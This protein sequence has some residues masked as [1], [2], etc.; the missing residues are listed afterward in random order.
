MTDKARIQSEQVI[1]AICAAI[2]IDSG[3]FSPARIDAAVEALQR[4]LKAQ[5]AEQIA[6]KP[7]PAANPI[8]VAQAMVDEDAKTT[9]DRGT[10]VLGAGIVISDRGRKGRPGPIVVIRSP[11]QGNI[12]GYHACKR[13]IEYLNRVGIPAIWYD[14]VID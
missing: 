13:A 2:G 6:P 10:C 9:Q 4:T 7:T 1:D 5:I 14:G 12:G 8:D 11:F 3:A